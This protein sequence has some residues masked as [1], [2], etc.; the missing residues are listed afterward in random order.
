LRRIAPPRSI[1]AGCVCPQSQERVVRRSRPSGRAWGRILIPI[2]T[3]LTAGAVVVAA[4]VV[5]DRHEGS[6]PDAEILAEGRAI[7][8]A[9]C[10]AC[11]VAELEG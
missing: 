9:E 2:G 5:A 10:A 11:H 8:D 7:Y 6:P 1:L 4:S 3:G